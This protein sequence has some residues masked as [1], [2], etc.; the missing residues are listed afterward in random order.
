MLQFTVQNTG[1]ATLTGSISTPTGYSVD[2]TQAKRTGSSS[3]ERS[4]APAGKNAPA[5]FSAPA[6][7]RNTLSFDIPAGADQAYDLT[8]TPTAAQDYPGYVVISSNDADE[9]TVNIL[10]SGTGQISNTEPSIAL[11]ESF[12]FEED[13][14]L[15]VDFAPY[16]EDAQTPDSGLTLGYSGNTDVTVSIDGLSVTFGATG[17]WNGTEIITFTVGDGELSASAA[18]DVIVTPVNDP[19]AIVL[20]DSFTFA[21]DGSLTVDFSGYV[22]DL[23]TPEAGLTLGYSGNTD[24]TVS[25]DGLSVT[26]GATGN[27]NGTETITFTVGDGELSASA[28]ADVIVTPVNDTPTIAL[29]ENLD[30]DMNSSLVQDFSPYVSDIEANTLSLDYSGNTN[31]LIAIDGLQVT[32]TA[33]PD[34]YGSEEITFSVFDG[35]DYAYDTVTV[36]VNFVNHAPTLTLPVEGFEFDLNESLMV[37]FGPYIEDLD[38]HSVTLS[39][40]DSDYIQAAIDGHSV[41]FSSPTDW[42]GSETLNFVVD[43][44]YASGHCS[45]EV[46]VNLNYLAVPEAV[47][48]PNAGGVTVSWAPVA[49]ANRYH[50][51]RAADPYGNYEPLTTVL[52]PATSWEDPEALPMAFYKVVA[53]FEDLPAKQ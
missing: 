47:V 34:W 28:A 9:P 4:A 38:G 13:G 45:V 37:D 42:F 50:I 14:S 35:F 10:L 21:E 19:P 24:V 2:L 41:T 1:T 15:T 36:T 53:A 33:T 25:I 8:F 16:V 18:A 3:A 40:G 20:P 52:A 39:V 29:P 23:E 51:Y 11:P 31:F 17:N 30:F 43:D 7:Q 22:T 27:W 6:T 5:L 26:F 49:N 46:R 12:S 44:G 48:V 32:F